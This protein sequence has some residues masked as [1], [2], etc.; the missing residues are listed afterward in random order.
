MAAA[1]LR[2]YGLT[3]C[4]TCRAARKW[5]AARGFDVSFIDLRAD[6]VEAGR[7][8]RWLAALGPSA[9]VNRRST[10]WRGLGAAARARADDA[11]GAAG[12][13]AAHPTLIKRP[14]IEAGGEVS[15]GF[16]ETV[17]SRLERLAGRG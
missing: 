5:A 15:V 12:L 10:T 7:L 17:R 1:G 2:L 6:G 11:A 14:V 4:D 3:G 13:L 9:L 16:D 8:D